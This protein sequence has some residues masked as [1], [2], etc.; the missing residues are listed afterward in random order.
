MITGGVT[1]C[2]ICANE[3]RL[4]LGERFGRFSIYS[5]SACEIQFAHPLSYSTTFYDK[6]YSE[7]GLDLTRVRMLTRSSMVAKSHRMMSSPQALA[8]RWLKRNI[9]AHSV[10]LEVGFGRGW[11]LSAL[12]QRGYSAMGTEVAQ[13]PVE[14][15]REK[16]FA[17][18]LTSIESLPPDWPAPRAV[19]L[20]EVLEHLPDPLG[21]LGTL[22]ENFPTAPLILSTPSPK[23]WSLRLGHRE[24]HDY[25]P[26]HLTRWTER[27]LCLALQKAGYADAMC[28]YPQIDPAEFYS[29]LLGMVLTRSRL[30]N[31][32]SPELALRDGQNRPLLKRIFAQFPGFMLHAHDIGLAISRGL[33]GPLAWYFNR[34]GWSSSS[35]L[36]IGL[37]AGWQEDRTSL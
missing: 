37:P 12:E 25:P 35:M 16:G 29:T 32:T 26:Y 15:L 1:C 11:F 31:M 20:L 19:I 7:G 8:L 4:T 27:A 22:H 33:F 9:P 34:R 28:L 6:H 36:A 2:P 14:L 17:V 3:D 5:C 30:V 13:E 23:R 18:S 10:V 21:F 24:S